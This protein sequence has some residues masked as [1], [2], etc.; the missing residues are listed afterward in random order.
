MRRNPSAKRR[1]KVPSRAAPEPAATGPRASSQDLRGRG[2]HRKID[3]SHRKEDTMR[4][5]V[6]YC[7]PTETSFASVLHRTVLQALCSR[8]H[9]IMDLDLY[10]EGFRAAMSRE[11]RQEYEDPARYH[12][13]V[14][15]YASQ[16]AQ[17]EAIVAVY[18]TWWYGLQ[19]MLKGHFDRVWAP[20]IGFDIGAD[21]V[22]ETDLLSHIRRLGVVT[23]YGSPWWLIRLYMGDPERKLWGRAI[24]KLCGRGCTLDWH[25]HYSMDTTTPERLDRFRKKTERAFEKW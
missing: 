20:G 19:A 4:V 1:I 21:G 15:K 8:G 2:C 7:H 5:L 11:E 12:E 23:T 24:R 9:E 14:A 25:V 10:A 22:F 16:L 3:H 13:T 17:A 6:I 18:P